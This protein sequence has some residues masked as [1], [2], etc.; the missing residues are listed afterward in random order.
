MFRIA[1]SNIQV[2]FSAKH[3]SGGKIFEE[4]R[5]RAMIGPLNRSTTS[6]LPLTATL[7]GTGSGAE[8]DP[9]VN[10]FISMDITLKF[11]PEAAGDIIFFEWPTSAEVFQVN[12][13]EPSTFTLLG[14]GAVG[15]IGCRRKKPARA[16]DVSF[17]PS[18]D[19]A[20]DE[21]RSTVALD[22]MIAFMFIAE[23][24]TL[25]SARSQNQPQGVSPGSGTTIPSNNR[26]VVGAHQPR[27]APCG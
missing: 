5:A 4:S 15:L 24:R 19:V 10:G 17:A 9:G 7:R 3:T 20:D 22:Q 2:N 21:T 8:I 25:W 18:V 23:I 16:A 1:C 11:T 26:D 13:P 14:L 6:V 12:I 27:L